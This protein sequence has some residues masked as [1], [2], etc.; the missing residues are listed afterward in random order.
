[1]LAAGIC[2]YLFC[3]RSLYHTI[4]E[5]VTTRT[6][7]PR[8]RPE[9]EKG[10]DADA[11]TIASY[12]DDDHT[13]IQWDPNLI[14]D[15]SPSLSGQPELS[16]KSNLF[17]FFR[18]AKDS[19][20]GEDIQRLS[21][22]EQARINFA[23]SIEQRDEYGDV[24][25]KLTKQDAQNEKEQGRSWFPSR[26]NKQKTND[27]EEVVPVSDHLDPYMTQGINFD[28]SFY[29]RQVA[30]GEPSDEQMEYR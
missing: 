19:G 26:G 3:F 12:D 29:D 27:A 22:E 10:K 4:R 9:A 30:Q 23:D 21:P 1:M 2:I 14:D 6:I 5:Q 11:C 18:R 24:S 16:E 17:S 8:M 20:M 28:R 13:K 25:P 7:K 15:R